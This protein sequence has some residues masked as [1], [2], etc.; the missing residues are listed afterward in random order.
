MGSDRIGSDHSNTQA[1]RPAQPAGRRTVTDIGDLPGELRGKIRRAWLVLAWERAWPRAAFPLAVLALFLITALFGLWLP[2]PAWARAMALAAFA[3]S[4]LAALVP[5]VRTELPSLA[6]AVDLLDARSG[7]RHRPAASYIDELP[8]ARASPAANTV[9]HEH[10]RRLT[11]MLSGLA[12]GWPRSAFIRNDPYGLRAALGLTLLIAVIAAGPGWRERLVSPF[13]LSA[14]SSGAPLQ[15]DAWVNP[16]AYTARPPLFLTG[17]AGLDATEHGLIEVPTASQIVIRVQGDR[18]ATAAFRAAATPNGPSEALVPTTEADGVTEYRTELRRPGLVEVRDGNARAAG[19]TFSLIEDA[20][21]RIELSGEPETARSGALKLSYEVL[22]DYGVV[23]A[24]AAI[25]PAGDSSAGAAAEPLIEAPNLPLTLPGLRARAGKAQTYSDLT[26]HPW[27]GS[28][29]ELTLV[30]YDEAGQTG[31]S[32]SARLV[33]PQ[34]EFQKPLARAVVEQRRVLAMDAGA[35]TRVAKALDALTISPR[36]FIEDTIVYLGLRSASARLRLRHDRDALISVVE[37]LWDVALRIED[38][39]LS[40]AERDLRAAQEALQNA[41]AEGAS[42]EEI[43]RLMDELRQALDRYMRSLAENMQTSPNQQ[44]PQLG[45]NQVIRPEDL[46]RMLDTIENLARSGARD[47]AQQMLSELQDILENLQQQRA[48]GP[49]QQQQ[50]MSQSLQEL[51]E[52][53]QRQQ[54]LRDQTYG[55]DQNRQSREGGTPQ[56]PQNG[57][58]RL[59]GEQGELQQALQ[60][61]IDR[62]AEQG[63]PAPSLQDADRNMGDAGDALG[64]GQTGE[65][66][67]EQGEA[68][69]NLRA[70]AQAL[71]D[72]LAQSL[73]NAQGQRGRGQR[74]P[75]GRPMPT[76]GPDLGTTVKVPDEI[77]T[78]RAREILQELRRRLGEQYRPLLELDYLERLLTP[79]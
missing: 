67:G 41:L 50:M 4:G 36:G 49:S 12:T 32:Q 22:D 6:E 70:G 17:K 29:V 21:P 14:L 61:L 51:S 9:W 68:M 5:L 63:I 23:R 35:R 57:T 19:W 59:Q 11:A 64:E 52:M 8:L 1:P 72:Q 44:A 79:F 24:E 45:D 38:G 46:A 40:L 25:E 20:P 60:A 10:K 58:E 2:L 78:L 66:V 73:A 42:D 16:P 18:G 56:Q 39:D 54:Q 47:Q 75:A 69:E 30:A 37:Q 34:R 74:D 55:L 71:A 15:I 33:L 62:L 7:V 76:E 77:E 43:A 65:A 27:A 48:Q 13:L 3:V 26:A 28:E 31:R 53:L